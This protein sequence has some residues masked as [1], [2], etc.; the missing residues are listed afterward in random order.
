VN[1]KSYNWQNKAASDGSDNTASSSKHVQQSEVIGGGQRSTVAPFQT[2]HPPL[3][4]RQLAVAADEFYRVNPDELVL[5]FRRHR[6]TQQ[7]VILNSS[8]DQPVTTR[9]VS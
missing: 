5:G 1:K 8:R 9:Q 3:Q 2:H 6:M 4:S 7:R